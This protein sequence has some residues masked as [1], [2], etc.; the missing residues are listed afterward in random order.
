M[1]LKFRKRMK[2]FPGFYLNLSKSGMSATVGMRGFSVNVGQKGTYLNTGIPGTGLYDRQRIG[3][4][5]RD[6]NTPAL[7]PQLTPEPQ[8]LIPEG[9]E[10]KSFEPELI[11]SEGLF[12]LKES[13]I[14]AQKEKA[15]LLTES[16]KAAKSKLLAQVLMGF[17]YVLIFG[18]F[19]PKIRQNAK[20][21]AQAALDAKEEYENFKLDIEMNLDPSMQNDYLILKKSFEDL[22]NIDSIWDVTSASEVNKAATRSAADTAVTRTKVIF[23]KGSLAFIATPFE[24]LKFHNANGGDIF[25]YPGFMVMV[26]RNSTDFALIDFRDLEVEHNDVK[27]LETDRIPKDTKVI[28]RTWKYV[29]KNGQPDRRFKENPEIPIVHY[30]QLTLKTDKGLYESYL[31]SNPEI[32]EKLCAA[33]NTYKTSLQKMKWA[34]EKAA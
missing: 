22:M 23:G 17:S 5:A 32:A 7:N 31:F 13:I 12:G 30:Y 24:A 15:D 8:P 4:G 29:N 19:V 34:G 28:G 3:G 16:K 6:S 9:A 14:N 33:L 27:F 1:A 2:L 26:G 18:F 21:K 25:L 20:D 10:I 11:T